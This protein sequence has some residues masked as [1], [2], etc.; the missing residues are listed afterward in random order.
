MRPSRLVAAVAV[1]AAALV[2]PGGCGVGGG[3]GGDGE[4]EAGAELCRAAEAQLQA[5]SDLYDAAG[6]GLPADEVAATAGRARAA[7]RDL[8]EAAPDDLADDAA[9]LAGVGDRLAESLAT[10]GPSPSG[11]PDDVAEAMA[12]PEYRAA[13]DRMAVAL[14]EECGAAPGA[15]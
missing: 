3:G 9:V 10:D 7:G 12:S 11:V 2:A 6:A 5:L 1:A 8:V 4:G 15:A 14:E 13:S